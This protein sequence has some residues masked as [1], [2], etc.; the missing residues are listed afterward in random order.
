MPIMRVLFI[1]GEYNL[2]AEEKA[3]ALYQ[4]HLDRVGGA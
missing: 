1:V 3:E 2:I 4:R